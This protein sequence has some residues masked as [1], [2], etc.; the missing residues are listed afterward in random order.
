MA[1]LL[2]N[3]QVASV[4]AKLGREVF[5]CVVPRLFAKIRKEVL[6]CFSCRLGRC[7]QDQ[8]W[9]GEAEN[10]GQ[11]RA[12]EHILLEALDEGFHESLRDRT[13]IDGG[14][15]RVHS[16]K[17]QLQVGYLTMK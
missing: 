5:G 7:W 4:G 17:S 8:Q 14:G 16:H 3:A 15:G 1:Q 9:F 10:L 6:Y 13:C 2:R 11:P 12:Q